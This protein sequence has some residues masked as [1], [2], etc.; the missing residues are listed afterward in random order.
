M[1][2]KKIFVIAVVSILM[3]SSCGKKKENP[4]GLVLKNDI[5]ML[6]GWMPGNPT[7]IKGEGHSGKYLCKVDSAFEYSYGYSCL[8]KDIAEK[9]IQAV[10]FSAWC[11]VDM[12]PVKDLSLV[13]Q[14]V[15]SKG[16][17]LAWIGIPLKDFIKKPYEWT[18][19]QGELRLPDIQPP[20][21]VLCVY[22][23]NPAKETAFIDDYEIILK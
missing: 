5:D 12:L 2:T 14:V 23:W 17:N 4:D 11:K 22:L 1:N 7:I 6:I 9:K 21:A 16:E 8:L 18:Q 15:N 20:D 13:A 19:V 10:S 3:F